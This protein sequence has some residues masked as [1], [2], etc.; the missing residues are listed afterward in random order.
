MAFLERNVSRG[1][2]PIAGDPISWSVE[3][4]ETVEAAGGQQ[5]IALRVLLFLHGTFST[6]RGSF[7][8]LVSSPAG[9]EFLE[10]AH[11]KYDMVIGFDHP[12]LSIDPAQNAKDLVVALDRLGSGRSMDVDVVSYSRGGLV[13]RALAQLLAQRTDI[14]FNR[15]CFVAVPNG[16]TTLAEPENWEKFIN[17]YTNIAMAGLR[18][19]QLQP[20][21]LSATLVGKEAVRSIGAFV[22]Y[23]ASY[24]V[25]DNGVPG[26]AAMRPN[27]SFLTAMSQDTKE[28]HR[29]A[30]ISDF[31][32]ELVGEG[33]IAG[34][35]RQILSKIADGLV[36]ELLGSVNDLVVNTDSMI[37]FGRETARALSDLLDFGTT[38]QV[39]HTSYFV[40]PE[41]AKALSRWLINSDQVETDRE[42][43]RGWGAATSKP[44][45]A[46]EESQSLVVVDEGDPVRRVLELDRAGSTEFIVIRRGVHSYAFRPSEILGMLGATSLNNVL[47]LHDS[48]ASAVVGISSEYSPPN[49]RR[50]KPSA[51][52]GIV[53]DNGKPVAVIHSDPADIGNSADVSGGQLGRFLSNLTP[54]GALAGAGG[55][56]IVTS[57]VSDPAIGKQFPSLE[58][59]SQSGQLKGVF[60][61]GTL[62]VGGQI[63]PA[64]VDMFREV[65]PT[66][67]GSV[68][69]LM[70]P[71][72]GELLHSGS[73]VKAGERSEITCHFL[74]ELSKEIVV[75]KSS[76][77]RVTISREELDAALGSATQRGS[78]SKVSKDVLLIVEAWP[79]KNL[80]I[81]R[82]NRSE[83]RVPASNAPEYAYFDLI[84]TQAGPAEVTVV[85][86]QGTYPLASMDVHVTA[87][88]KAPEVVET[89]TASST[90][91]TTDILPAPINQLRIIDSEDDGK[92]S[93]FYEL[94]LPGITLERFQSAPIKGDRTT[95]VENL[96]REIE[97]RYATSK[98]KDEEFRILLRAMGA[99]LFKELFPTELQS[100]LWKHKDRISGIQV[101]STE[102]FVPW[103][104]VFLKNPNEKGLKDGKFLAELGL[105]RWVHGSWHPAIVRARMNRCHYV[106]SEYPTAKKLPE[107]DAEA[108][109]LSEKFAFQPVRPTLK[110]VYALLESGFDVLHFACHGVANAGDISNAALEL[111]ARHG[112]GWELDELKSSVVG[113]IA[114]LVSAD[115]ERP[116]VVLNACQSSRQGWQ[117]TSVGG[118]AQAFVGAGAGIFVGTLW[119]VIDLPARVFIEALYNSLA[120]GKTLG[121]AAKDARLASAAVEPSSWLAYT[122]YGD[123]SA[124]VIMA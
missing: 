74:A 14:S 80:R 101:I 89:V 100:L 107:A 41:V 90:G 108:R 54:I 1:I 39:Y 92:I 70:Q 75:A 38:P 69:S 57:P 7:G 4:V 124:K 20:G 68:G 5:S 34:L 82:E 119:S 51:F 114:N 35:P 95:Y 13:Y 55:G 99:E 94:N 8:A 87:V 16:G 111:S 32:P 120:A 116:M 37:N 17:L 66:R 60:H 65:G 81:S 10:Q 52:R 112:S 42:M 49:E 48:D 76:T 23:L 64:S 104:L 63:N 58:A 18:L 79:R 59:A 97:A 93:F 33:S 11:N 2:V 25:A 105:T 44:L 84:P 22:R 102:P 121:E 6:T 110:D 122:V 29:Y 53:F 71:P 103:E 47:P 45:L 72:L 30:V 83:L 50:G 40:R 43:R 12:T 36:D 61:H 31:E 19:L 113:Q 86:R 118:F 27:S 106:A 56:P 91:R 9:K 67:R 46:P 15:V 21:A 28:V 24:A 98:Q 77:L 62:T 3:T 96:F 85:V 78:S 117:L 88:E 115:G 73:E 109:F 26:L 123:P